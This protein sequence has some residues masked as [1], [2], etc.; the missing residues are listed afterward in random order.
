MISW[1][2]AYRDHQVVNLVT[3]VTKDTTALPPPPNKQLN[4]KKF[5][6]LKMAHSSSPQRGASGKMLTRVTERD[7]VGYSLP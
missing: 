7:I 5:S 1:D 3:L 6:Y 4:T 2:I